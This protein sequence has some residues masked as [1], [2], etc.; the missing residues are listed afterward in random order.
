[1]AL[2]Y[3]LEQLLKSIKDYN[4]SDLH[5]N[6]N[7]EPKLRIDG[8]L[9]ALNLP[10]LT[11]ED[12]VELCYSVLTEKQKASLEE[13]LELDFSFEIPKVARFRANYYFERE[14]LAA[15][16]RI[17]PERPLTLDELNAPEIFKRII[18]REKGLILV[19]GPTGSGK[20]TTLYASL[21][22]INS[23][24]KKIITVE[25]PVEYKLKGIQQVQVNPKVGL[26]FADALRSILRQDPDIIMIGEIRDL[27]TLEIAI[28]AAMT[29]HLVLSTLHTN[30]A[31][32][33]ISRM[34]DMGADAF[35]V[36]T[37]LIGVEAQRLVKTICPYCKTTYKP[38]DVYLD[39]VRNII[40]KDSVF[41][42]GK[43]CEKCNMTGYAGRTLI[44]EVFL[45]DEELESMISKNK[46][47]LELL[48]YLRGKD[49]KT[50][51]YD[52]LIKALNGITTLEE[53]YKVAKL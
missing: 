45:C 28:K 36:A 4:A 53:V 27:E 6:V 35:L 17:I 19:T 26:T 5:L 47:K 33:A 42:K 18:K 13:T 9:T 15:A 29:G 32:S 48:H 2:T 43:G 41:Y 49:Y 10:K 3:T 11:K 39:P 31:V 24:D 20:S 44:T 25:D 16:F 30:D 12:V 38:A 21:H 8:K 22:E 37:A 7:S 34:L 40:P 51:F 23:V 50:M 14:N 52:G 1:M 46:E